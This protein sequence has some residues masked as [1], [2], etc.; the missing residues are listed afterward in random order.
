MFKKNLLVVGGTGFLG[1]HFSK[2][3]VKKKFKT[4]S[5]SLKKVNHQNKVKGVTYLTCDCLNFN[6]LK[7]LLNNRKF[8]YVINCSGYID[9]NNFS[10][11]FGKKSL[12]M[13][14]DLVRNL[15]MCLNFKYIK[16]FIQIGSSDEYGKSKCPQAETLR[17]SPI[18]PYSLG[19]TA[20][21]H[22]L[23]MLHLTEHYKITIV[24]IFLAYGPG[25]NFKRFFP[26]II[27]GCLTNEK[28]NTSSGNQLRDFLYIDDIVS[29]VF[30][31][32]KC[33]KADG[34]IVNIGSGKGIKI[35][36]LIKKV[37]KIV[38]KGQ[39]QFGKIKYRKGENMCLVANI[40]KLKNLIKWK[41]KYSL[42]LG[43]KKTIQYYEEQL[44]STSK[45]NY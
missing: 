13:H 9:H 32:L 8:D 44:K 21:S 16:K 22:F 35:K 3:S 28:F 12:M 11:N 31:I 19:K 20:V 37:V 18:S 41:P 1:T 27:K 33:K 29:A 25:Q 42:H 34:E 43:L 14:F 6:K 30:Q 17:E 24:R 7:N 15:L 10:N 40:K 36:N 45:Y 26:Q 23:Q 39:P 38:G 5:L 4:Y 2:A